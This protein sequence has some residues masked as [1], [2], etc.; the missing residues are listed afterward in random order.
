MQNKLEFLT[1][2]ALVLSL[3]ALVGGERRTVVSILR[4][5]NELDRRP[6]VIRTGFPSLFEYCVRELK[7]A[8][9]ETARRIHAARAAKKYP[10]LYRSI[11]RGLLSLTVVSLLAP[12]LKWD[13]YRKLIRSSIGRST[14]EVEALIAS[15]APVAASPPER[16]R[17]LSVVTKPL[18]VDVTNFFDPPGEPAERGGS[19]AAPLT[20]S[21]PAMLERSAP[22][23]SSSIRRV[24]FSFT[25]DEALLRDVERAKELSRHRWP[26]GKYEDVFAGA[27]AA[28]LQKIDPERKKARNER[29][30]KGMAAARSRN[31]A[32]AVKDEVWKRDAGRC[33][34]MAD[35]GRVCGTRAGLEFDHIRPFALGGES[36]AEN[37]RLL[38]RS[39]NGAEARRVFGG[40]AIDAAIDRRRGA[41]RSE[42]KI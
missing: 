39:H 5:L 19:G 35:N 17:F 20:E 28:L 1:D 42:V 37:L 10:I 6:F 41:L 13:N 8:Q 25:G 21:A 38:C 40:S 34:F 16:I 24:Q 22:S 27:V 29:R 12:H 33:A 7:Y 31:I 32:H 9:G 14:R 3:K 30:R 2:E 26:A 36:T 4:H 11:E 18:G 15:L 23:A